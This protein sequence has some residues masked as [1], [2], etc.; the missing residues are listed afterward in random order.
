MQNLALVRSLLF[1]PADRPDRF[2]KAA[3][4]GA[5]GAV[6]DLEDGVGLPAKQKAREAAMR[7]FENPLTAPEGF[8]WAVRLNHVTT[9]DGLKDLLAFRTAAYRPKVVMLPKTESVSEVDIAIRHLKTGPDA[10]Q[11]IALIETGRGLGAAEAIAAQPSIGAIA[12]GG[13]DLAADLHATLAW[14]PM[15]FPRSRIVQ[16][17]AAAGIA[18]FDVPFLDIHDAEGLRKETGMAMALG[19]SCKL[20]IHPAQIAVI[21]AVFTPSAKELAKAE[22]IVAAFEQAHG[23]ACQVDGRMV[24]VPVVKAA[25][26]TVALAGQKAA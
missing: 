19:Y 21:N 14:E 1:T 8:V 5:D 16:A 13:A 6:L 12:F 10:P 24:D 18:A 7:F 23:G 3:T 22:R 4:V 25:Q 15:L 17:A 2:A 20:A 26:R 11:I 9:E